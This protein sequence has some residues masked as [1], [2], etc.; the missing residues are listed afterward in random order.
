MLAIV[1][2]RWYTL[3]FVDS[4]W[5]RGYYV[6]LIA[7]WFSWEQ[8]KKPLADAKWLINTGLIGITVQNNL[9]HQVNNNKKKG[10]FH[11]WKQKS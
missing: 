4:S 8:E 10:T 2:N 7:T 9:I 6:W 11:V 5:T 1:Q 3:I